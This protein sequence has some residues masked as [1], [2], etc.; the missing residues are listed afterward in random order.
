MGVT[1]EVCRSSGHSSTRALTAV[2]DTHTLFSCLCSSSFYKHTP[3]GERAHTY[4]QSQTCSNHCTFVLFLLQPHRIVHSSTIVALRVHAW[5]LRS[6][7]LLLG[8]TPPRSSPCSL[9]PFLLHSGAI[10]HNNQPTNWTWLFSSIVRMNRINSFKRPS[11][12]SF[13]TLHCGCTEDS[14]YKSSYHIVL[15]NIHTNTTT[16]QYFA[17]E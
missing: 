4:I 5:H 7:S 2:A 13:A 11:T 9:H 6:T 14:W 3:E 16:V 8:R 1:N 15:L 17:R 10:I 12:A